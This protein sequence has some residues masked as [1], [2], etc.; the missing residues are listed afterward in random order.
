MQNAPD[1]HGDAPA[2]DARKPRVSVSLDPADHAALK[3]IAE[4]RR[5]S[6]AWVVREAVSEYISQRAPLFRR[7]SR[8]GRPP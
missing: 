2:D 3:R 4:E 5:V 7:A 8:A 1:R 6:L